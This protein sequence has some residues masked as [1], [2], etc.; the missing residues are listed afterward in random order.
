MCILILSAG[1]HNGTTALI[2]KKLNR[3]LIWLPCRHHVFEIILRGIFEV[4]WTTTSG[5]NIPIFG[6]FRNSWDK[7]NQSKYVSGMEDEV[8][9]NAVRSERFEIITFINHHLA[10]YHNNLNLNQLNLILNSEMIIENF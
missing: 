7:I 6:R 9:A 3:K 8:V 5:P 4:Y 10:V 1:I 2:E